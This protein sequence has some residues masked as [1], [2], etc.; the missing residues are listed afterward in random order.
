MP[1][2]GEAGKGGGDDGKGKGGSGTEDDDE[3]SG[4]REAT[5]SLLGLFCMYMLLGTV[6]GSTHGKQGAMA[7]PHPEFWREL[8]GLVVDGYQFFFYDRKA[9][10]VPVPLADGGDDDRN[11]S[12]AQVLQ[13][14]AGKGLDQPPAF[15]VHSFQQ[16]GRGRGGSPGTRG[17]G[18]RGRG[19]T[20]GRGSAV[21]VGAP[22][23]PQ[24]GARALVL[25]E[26]GS[27]VDGR[28]PTRQKLRKKKGAT[29]AAARLP[30]KPHVVN[31]E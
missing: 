16:G 6:Y 7:L 17:T 8:R 4:A 27:L 18:G 21:P 23:P 9:N 2:Q 25:T 22:A 11:T 31:M 13:I 20:R 10:Y 15:V 19:K 3:Y 26:A 28:G 30:V 24:A 29:S 5:F 1:W 12:Q 14:Q